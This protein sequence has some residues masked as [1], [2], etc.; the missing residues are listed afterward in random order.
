MFEKI[1]SCYE[2]I[3]HST[4]LMSRHLDKLSQWDY[5]WNELWEVCDNWVGEEKRGK[6]IPKRGKDMVEC[7]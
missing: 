1:T 2:S 3:Y 7:S 5:E 6:L 4:Q